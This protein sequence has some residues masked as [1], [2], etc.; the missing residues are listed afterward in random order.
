MP[1]QGIGDFTSM[2]AIA[3][4]SRAAVSISVSVSVS[5][6]FLFG[7]GVW[8]CV[9]VLSLSLYVDTVSTPCPQFVISAV[10]PRLNSL[11]QERR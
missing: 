5:V 6:L 1:V 2:R 3:L 4:F 9:S 8:V 7:Y 10:A 11:S